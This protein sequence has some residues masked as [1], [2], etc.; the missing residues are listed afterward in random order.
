MK[1]LLQ[2][3]VI[4]MKLPSANLDVFDNTY[5]ANRFIVNTDSNIH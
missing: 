4:S 1:L 2:Y 3:T 5:V